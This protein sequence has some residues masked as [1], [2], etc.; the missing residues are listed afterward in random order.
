MMFFYLFSPSLCSPL[1]F[2]LPFFLFFLH[3]LMY[4]T[5]FILIRTQTLNF[6][7]TCLHFS[8]VGFQESM[9]MLGLCGAGDGTESFMSD[10]CVLHKYYIPRAFSEARYMIL[11]TTFKSMCGV[12]IWRCSSIFMCGSET[13][14]SQAVCHSRITF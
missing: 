10:A 8:C 11:L 2:F 9:S 5:I 6:S 3:H 4:P 1:L 12:V 7:F 13:L 14:P